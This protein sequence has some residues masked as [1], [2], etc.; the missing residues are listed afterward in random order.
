MSA[1]HIALLKIERRSKERHSLIVWTFCWNEGKEG[2]L[3][4]WVLFL[5][6]VTLDSINK[7]PSS[8]A[9]SQKPFLIPAP[10]SYFFLIKCR[11][12]DLVVV[13]VA[14]ESLMRPASEVL[15]RLWETNLTIPFDNT[16]NKH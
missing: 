11:G 10:S 5:L 4:S 8:P 14:R 3:F 7:L 15:P 6:F 9:E 13:I 1:T 2:E 12:K 16:T